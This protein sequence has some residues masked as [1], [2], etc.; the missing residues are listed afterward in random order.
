MGKVHQVYRAGLH[1][2][3]DGPRDQ[4]R[5]ES[6]SGESY[7]DV[8]SLVVLFM[9]YSSLVVLLILLKFSRL[10]NFFI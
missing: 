2:H 7:G 3:R 4:K 1:D 6:P 9:F 5:A 8:L 10:S